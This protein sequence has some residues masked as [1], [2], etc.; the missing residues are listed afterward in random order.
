VACRFIT[1]SISKPR[2]RLCD[3]YGCFH[4]AAAMAVV[5]VVSSIIPERVLVVRISD[6]ESGYARLTWK[7]A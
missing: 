5:G 1:P 6:N 4:T 7:T 2:M 3:R